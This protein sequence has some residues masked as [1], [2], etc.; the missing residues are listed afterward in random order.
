MQP[1]VISQTL[2]QFSIKKG[3]ALTSE[4][5]SDIRLALS[6]ISLQLASISTPPSP[7]PAS[8]PID[9]VLRNFVTR[10]SAE[11]SYFYRLAPS[12]RI[13]GVHELPDIPISHRRRENSMTR[14]RA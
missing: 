13:R 3:F 11:S 7:P 5:N 12:T 2:Q 4:P 8:V 1:P 9:V 6:A 14:V 10:A